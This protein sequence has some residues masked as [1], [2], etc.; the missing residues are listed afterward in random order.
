MKNNQKGFGTVES[1]LILIIVG[2]IG[3]IGWYVWDSKNDEPVETART[4]QTIKKTEVNKDKIPEGYTEFKSK[5]VG[6]GFAYPKD[7]GNA[8]LTSGPETSHLIKGSEYKISF[9]KDANITAGLVSKDREHDPAKGHG[10]LLYAGAFV[11]SDFNYAD[12]KKYTKV[13]EYEASSKTT[14]F[15]GPLLAIGC[16]GVGT[17]LIKSI[18]GNS[19]Y[20][21]IAFMRFDKKLDLDSTS[22]T[23]QTAICDN[24]N[25]YISKSNVDELK[26]LSGTVKKY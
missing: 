4:V 2:L 26:K 21:S 17:V 14:L 8:N 3:F 5:V 13:T 6:V 24:Y 12:Y 15:S 19:T 7:W 23:D 18:D 11:N 1:V 22:E 10:G 16:E 9:S 25:S 20:G